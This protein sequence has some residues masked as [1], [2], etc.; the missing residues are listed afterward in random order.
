MCSLFAACIQKVRWIEIF[1]VFPFRNNPSFE[2]RDTYQEHFHPQRF[3]V[4]IIFILS[5][6]FATMSIPNKLPRRRPTL[7]VMAALLLLLMN[8]ILAVVLSTQAGNQH[9]RQGAIQT[10]VDTS[11]AFSDD[12]FDCSTITSKPEVVAT[13]SV[14]P[15][16]PSFLMSLQ[17]PKKDVV[18]A[19]ISESGCMDCPILR[20]LMLQLQQAPENAIFLDMGGNVGMYA[21]SA[22][23]L[24]RTVY[25]FEPFKA[26]YE[27]ICQSV[28]MNPGFANRVILHNRALVAAEESPVTLGFDTY[29]IQRQDNYGGVYVR[30]RSLKRSEGKEGVNYITGV[31]LDSLTHLPKNVPVVLKI[32]TE[33]DE[34]KALLGSLKYL[35]TVTIVYTSVEMSIASM[36][37]CGYNNMERILKFFRQQG[38]Q[39]YQRREENWIKLD[40][41]DWQ[42]WEG[43]TDN[44][45]FGSFEVAFSKQK[46]AY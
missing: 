21:L 42:K 18:S 22:A 6:T 23:A 31:S 35:S 16:G 2:N 4:S 5:T 17:D 13:A 14:F 30:P 19:E 41:F 12:V 34:C 45:L 8:F 27:K 33:G 3:T 39:P 43:P 1:H 10:S 7:F 26:S 28:R 29:S 24:G 9:R 36:N 38:L 37:T 25:T 11:Y 20:S 46:P 40:P 32:D 15:E 44:H